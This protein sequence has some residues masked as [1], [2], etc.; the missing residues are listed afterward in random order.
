MGSVIMHLDDDELQWCLEGAKGIVKHYSKKGVNGSGSY[1]HNK[2]SSNLVGFKSEVGVKKWLLLD[3]DKKDV[4]CHFEEYLIPNSKGDIEVFFQPLEVKGLRPKHWDSFQRCI[5]PHQ[6]KKYVEKDAIA[7]WTVASGDI[8]DNEVI[9][10]GW[11]Y[12]WEVEKYGEFIQ[13]ICANIWLKDPELMRP[14]DTLFDELM[15]KCMIQA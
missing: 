15:Y 11:N 4:K 10:K 6:L 3:F 1:N 14:M 2:V 5:P 13:T 12:C 7:I 9:L 8:M